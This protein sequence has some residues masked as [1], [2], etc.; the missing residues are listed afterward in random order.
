[1]SPAAYDK[2]PKGSYERAP[3]GAL[4][5]RDYS[6]TRLDAERARDLVNAYRKEKGLRP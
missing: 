6:H 1:M 5:E 3:R 2:A 4:A